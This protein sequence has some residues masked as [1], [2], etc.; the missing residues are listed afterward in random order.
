MVKTFVIGK[1]SC[2]LDA[3]SSPE[4]HASDPFLE[5]EI[6]Q[7][8]LACTRFCRVLGE[9]KEKWSASLMKKRATSQQLRAILRN[10]QS[11]AIYDANHDV[12]H[13]FY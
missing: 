1:G 8:V 2:L 5:H 3:P 7:R 10:I 4:A 13:L 11:T 6:D 12:S 9:F